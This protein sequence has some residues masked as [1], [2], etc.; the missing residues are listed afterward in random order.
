MTIKNLYSYLEPDGSLTVTTI[1]RNPEDEP[2]GV[3]LIADEGK[4]LV[5]GEIET[6]CIDTDT[7]EGWEEID[8]PPEPEPEAETEE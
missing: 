3:R 1:Q 8:A 7:P 4:I 6:T 2:S 5:K